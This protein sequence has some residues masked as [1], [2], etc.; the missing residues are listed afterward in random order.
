MSDSPSDE[1]PRTAH[2]IE[3]NI[4]AIIRLEQTALEN[5]TFG[6]RVAGAIG[7]F[8]GSIKFVVLQLSLLGVYFVVNRPG[9]SLAFDPFPHTWLMLSLALEA[10]LLST[11]V[12][13]NQQQMQKI[14]DRRA[15][16]NLQVD[17]LAETEMTKLL[18]T[19]QQ[20]TAHLGVPG[21]DDDED[22][23]ELSLPTEVEQVAQVIEEQL[24][25]SAAE[26][27]R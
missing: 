21:V 19:F 13:I 18:T 20:L 9:S 27:E 23:R 15:H 17:L 12:L 8:I 14:A 10:I 24:S 11:F 6:D 22:L 5:R 26:P 25:G 1:A 7:N 4:A 16:L 2:H 3:R